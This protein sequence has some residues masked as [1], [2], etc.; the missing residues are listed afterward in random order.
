MELQDYLRIW[1]RNWIPIV[2]VTLLATAASAV[3]SMTRSPVYQ[4]K[5]QLYVSVRVGDA[6][7][8][9]LQQGSSVAKQLVTSY[10]D[11]V[12]TAIV[13]DGVS[14]EL[15]GTPT[16]AE[17]AKKLSASTPSNT[18]L[19]E[20]SATDGDA[21]QAA[22]I[23]NV[24]AS[25][26]TEVVTNRLE[27][28]SEGSP[29]RVQIDVVEPAS[30]PAS[31]ISPNVSRNVT[32]GFLLGLM[33]GLGFAVLRSVMDTRIRTRSDIAAITKDPVLGRIIYDP[34][35]PKRPLIVHDDPRSP[36]S[37]AFRTLRTNLQFLRVEGNPRSF[38]ITSS[39]PSEG[40]TTTAANLAIALAESGSTVCIV[41]GD[42]RK[43]RIAEIFGIEGAVGV[44]D[45]LIGRAEL[46]DALQRWGNPNLFVLPAG[47]RPPNPSE[48][49]GSQEMSEL[50]G[51]LKADFDYVIV[52]APPVL[53]VTDAALISKDVAGAL[54]VAAVGITRKDALADSL[55]SMSR[56]DAKVLGLIMTMVPPG[57]ADGY[58]YTAYAYGEVHQ[59]PGDEPRQPSA[60]GKW[61]SLN[62]AEHPGR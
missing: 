45:I 27:A 39:G 32:L 12:N 56:I 46:A 20:I 53:V 15:G 38:V 44:T 31:P 55:E 33:L 42:L 5:T 28:P 26:F 30:V 23:A 18:V 19:M 62:A 48:L 57:G 49:L 11:I 6:S 3:W 47:H 36:R 22:K 59:R 58:V 10:V 34:E 14:A 8:G 29:A 17:L 7:L 40:K 4:A 37:E 25:V 2:I 16:P 60:R 52:D 54:M 13:T 1:R 24:T 35:S 51:R 43:P 9:E 41:D 50:L 21:E 61:K